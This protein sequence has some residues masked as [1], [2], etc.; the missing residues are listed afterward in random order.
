M[1][2]GLYIT[3]SMVRRDLLTIFF[4]NPSKK[5]YL[6]ELERLLCYSAGN[7]RRELLKFKGDGILLTEQTGNLVFYTLN[8][9]HPLFRELK[10]L[11]SKTIGLEGALRN[12][13]C[14]LRGIKT[15]FIY[16]SFASGKEKATSDI[17]VM[18]IGD[19]N[20]SRLHELI[21]KLE[22]KL[23][24]EI[25]VTVYS[26]EEYLRRKSEHRG[27]ITELINNPKIMLA[28]KEDDL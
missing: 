21:M 8:I 17:D 20:N 12:V 1:L 14:G 28:G 10:S 26:R 27:F 4:T 6:R 24:R 9:R 7:I 15:A 11:I 19:F 5:Y 23:N 22:R 18:V 13:L 2:T 25:N 16:G 3:K